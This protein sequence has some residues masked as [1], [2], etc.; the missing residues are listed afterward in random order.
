MGTEAAIVATLGNMPP[1]HTEYGFTASFRVQS[2]QFCP[3][4]TKV[5]AMRKS[6]LLLSLF[7]AFSAL[8][9]DAAKQSEARQV[10]S[11]V[12]PKLL[13]VLSEQITKGGPASAIAVCQEKAP[14]MAKAASEQS[15]WAIRRVSL[16]NRNPKAVPDTWEQAALQDFDRRAAAGENP[17]T[18]ER[19]EVVST[20]ERKEYRYIKALPVQQLCLACHGPMDQLAPDVATQLQKLYPQDLGVGYALGLIR[21]A[22]TLRQP[23]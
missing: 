14:Q 2:M 12:P 17:A 22:I 21:G 3:P 6:L 16:R 23:M 5:I 7:A 1:T 13:A 11:A 4:L 8:A 19:W 9:D 20:P 15:G 18:L 10:A